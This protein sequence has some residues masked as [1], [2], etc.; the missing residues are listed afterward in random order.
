VKYRSGNEYNIAL[1]AFSDSPHGLQL[2]GVLPPSWISILPANAAQR[3]I[4]P[5]SVD[6]ST[7]T[8]A[9]SAQQSSIASFESRFSV[10][11]AP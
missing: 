3:N 8:P 5:E 2:R 9:E 6:S 1:S 7:L 10:R 4:S 11:D